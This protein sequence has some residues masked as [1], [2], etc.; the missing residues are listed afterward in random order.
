[1]VFKEKFLLLDCSIRGLLLARA[2]TGEMNA[3]QSNLTVARYSW[4]KKNVQ[5][6]VARMALS[7]GACLILL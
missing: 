7:A 6:C 2:L 1:M 3:E 4:V 5:L